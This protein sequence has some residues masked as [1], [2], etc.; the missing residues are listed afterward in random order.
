MLQIR[1]SSEEASQRMSKVRQ[2]GT[3]AEMAFRRELY[4]RGLRYR[5]GYTVL[6]KPRRVADIVFL[7][8]KIAIFIDGCFWHGCPIHATWPKQNAQFWKFKIDTNKARDVDTNERLHTLGW[9]VLRFWEHEE[10]ST[11][12]ENVIKLVNLT[13]I[14][15]AR[16]RIEVKK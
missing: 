11:S 8:Q 5:V 6:K 4:Q 7:K 9:T 14:N 3:N 10:T 16:Q 15:E 13:K 1:S 2:K 12:A